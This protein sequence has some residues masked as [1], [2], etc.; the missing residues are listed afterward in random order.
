M[1]RPKGFTLIEL[2]VVIAIIAILMAILMPA[3]QR[4]KKQARTVACQSNL[5]QWALYFSLYTDENNGHF[6]RG[7]NESADTQFSWMTVMRPY[8][9]DDPEL[10][11]CPTATKPRVGGMGEDA[12]FGAWT[13]F[14]DEHGS[15][16]INICVTDP[17]PGREGGRPAEWYWRKRD[18]KGAANIPLFLDDY[19]WDT[20][21]HHTDQPPQFEGQVDG[22]STN[23]MKMLCLN[24]H[25][26]FTNSVFVDFSSRTVGLKELWTLKWNRQFKIDG[27]WTRAG[28]VFPEDWPGWMKNFKDY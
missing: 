25:N 7:W 5:R 3:L 13:N 20:R 24:R 8:Y 15:Y 18:V 23:A 2:L 21:P 9:L 1:R 4:V 22:W 26:G 17:L 28:G 12:T 10:R 16:G 6:H 11:F 14:Y 19:W 27:D